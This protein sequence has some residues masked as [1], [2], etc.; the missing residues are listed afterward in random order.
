MGH[1]GDKGMVHRQVGQVDHTDRPA[2]DLDPDLAQLAVRALQETLDQ[3]EVVHGLQG[4]RMNGVPA[5]VA[6]EVGV[7]FQYDGLHPG[8]GQ[9]IA[10]HHPCRPAAGDAALNVGGFRLGHAEAPFDRGSL[11]GS[12]FARTRPIA[13]RR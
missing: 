3:A 2:I 6:Q 1:E 13:S 5:K 12:G 10:Q 4:R 9:Q 7:L 8:P 11:A